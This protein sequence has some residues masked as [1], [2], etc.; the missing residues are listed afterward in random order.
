MFPISHSFPVLSFFYIYQ[1]MMLWIW[2]VFAY[3]RMALVMLSVI[4]WSV[5]IKVHTTVKAERK[6]KHMAQHIEQCQVFRDHKWRT[7]SSPE[8]VV[9]DLVAI[10]SGSTMSCDATVLYGTVV[11]DES[12]LTGESRPVRKFA[13][14]RTPGA[15]HDRKDSKRTLFA[16]TTV[17]QTERE[18]G[19]ATVCASGTAK[20]A[21]AAVV[22]ATGAHSLKGRML[23]SILYPQEIAFT[24]D[25]ELNVVVAML[26]FWGLASA[27]LCAAF[28]NANAEESSFQAAWFCAMW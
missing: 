18:H 1:F 2:F 7:V 15:Q 24:F 22:T 27:I 28:T 5:S 12:M 23:R 8:L 19:A 25:K 21:S 17:L 20:Y 3:Y 14:D 16:G 9:G 11:V 13:V 6:V 10:E 4:V 26:G